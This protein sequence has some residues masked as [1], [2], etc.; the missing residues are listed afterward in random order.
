MKEIRILLICLL[1]CACTGAITY[2][3]LKRQSKKMAV[4]DAV[5]L[6][7]QFNMKKEMEAAAKMR[8][9][10]LNGQAD[11]VNSQLQVA[12]AA[13]DEDAIKRLTYAYSY[14]R[15]EFDREY[16]QSNRDI[17][18]QV[19]K[20]LNPS[21]EEFGKGKALHVI[22]GANGMGSVLYNDDYYDVT[23]ELINYVNSRYEG[24]N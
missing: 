9:D 12:R 21:V 14:F 11:S 23:D 24:K 1:M 20:R 8:L 22:I 3:L 18:E 10:R 16:T 5:K 15:S 4:A 6:F 7:D 19:W 2:V 13:H 17:N